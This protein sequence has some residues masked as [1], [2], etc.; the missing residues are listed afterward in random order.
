MGTIFEHIKKAMEKKKAKECGCDISVADIDKNKT[1]EIA[2][3]KVGDELYIFNVP[4]VVKE[5]IIPPGT[6]IDEKIC[7]W[8]CAIGILVN[9]SDGNDG[10]FPYAWFRKVKK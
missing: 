7:N 6:V 10:I 9:F 1:V 5:L 3:I 2:N 8:K 4:C